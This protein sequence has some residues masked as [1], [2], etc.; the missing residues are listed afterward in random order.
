MSEAKPDN[1]TKLNQP[2]KMKSFASIAF[3]GKFKPIHSEAE[4]VEKA[5]S[6][7]VYRL[8]CEDLKARLKDLKK[9][10]IRQRESGLGIV[11]ASSECG[12]VA[13]TIADYPRDNWLDSLTDSMPENPL[14]TYFLK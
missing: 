13:I 10:F 9:D 6:N 5:V 7:L 3:K 1:Q 12:C 2:K 14:V 8:A 4:T 11:K